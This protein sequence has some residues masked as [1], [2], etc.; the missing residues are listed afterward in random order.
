MAVSSF[1][2]MVALVLIEGVCSW[3]FEGLRKLLDDELRSSK[4]EEG[5]NK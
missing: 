2:S 5:E 4:L 1:S 3:S